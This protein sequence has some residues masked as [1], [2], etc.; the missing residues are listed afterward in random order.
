M[1]RTILRYGAL[2]AL[3]LIA[4][5]SAKR[6]FISSYTDLEIYIGLVAILFLAL[7]IWVA[8]KLLRRQATNQQQELRVLDAAE[9]SKREQEV[10]LFLCHG[11]TNNEI[12]DQLQ[13]TNNT[14]KSHLKN[15]YG[16]LG[17]TNRT[18]AAAEAKLLKII[19]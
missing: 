4:L 9:F 13:I 2:L 6:S 11:Y 12:A 14:V 5:E 10:L 1:Y 18:Q 19:G 15:I 17:V 3:F 8:L 16:K 7:G